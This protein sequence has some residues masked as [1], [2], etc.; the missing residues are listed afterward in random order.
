MQRFRGFAAS[1][2]FAAITILTDPALSGAADPGTVIPTSSEASDQEARS[3]ADLQPLQLWKEARHAHQRDERQRSHRWRRPNVLRRRHD[4]S[5]ERQGRLSRAAADGEHQ[6]IAVSPNQTGYVVAVA[7]DFDTGVP[8]DFNF[9]SGQ[10]AVVL[11]NKYRATIP[12]IALAK[13]TADN[14]LSDDGTLAALFLAGTPEAGSYSTVARV[15]Q[16]TDIPSAQDR[17]A[18]LVVVNRIGG[19]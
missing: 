17:T 12:A 9:L 10:A 5:R 18:T 14:V 6:G 15:L 16:V 1:I 3:G 13:L 7:I 19:A 8:L 4:R 11:P 2:L